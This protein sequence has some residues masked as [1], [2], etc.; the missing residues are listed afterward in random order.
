MGSPGEIIFAECMKDGLE[1][2]YTYDCNDLEEVLPWFKKVS[3]GIFGDVSDYD[4]EWHYVDMGMGNHLFVLNAVWESVKDNF[5]G[6]RPFE[7]Y[8]CWQGIITQYYKDVVSEGRVGDV[9]LC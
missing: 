5:I 6:K 3:W 8:G 9:D 2:L 7:I 4:P 1:Y